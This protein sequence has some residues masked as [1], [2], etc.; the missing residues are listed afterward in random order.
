MEHQREPITTLKQL[1]ELD[2]KEVIEGYMDGFEGTVNYVHN[3]SQSY[4]HG[5]KNGCSDRLVK[6]DWHQRVLAREVLAS[7][8]NKSTQE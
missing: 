8:K 3:R 1:A 2:D 4:Q 7:W 5:Y 6:V